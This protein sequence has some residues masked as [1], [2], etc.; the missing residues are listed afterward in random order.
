MNSSTAVR[1]KSLLRHAQTATGLL[2]ELIGTPC[3]NGGPLVHAVLTKMLAMH[4]E[5]S[6]LNMPHHCMFVPGVK[7]EMREHAHQSAATTC[8]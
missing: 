3:V 7:L 6:Q 4:Q 1:N 2:H 8:C 5:C